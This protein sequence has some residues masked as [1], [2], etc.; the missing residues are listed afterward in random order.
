MWELKTL[1]EISIILNEGTVQLLTDEELEQLDQVTES[2]R[3]TVT[4]EKIA[5]TI[6]FEKE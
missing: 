1:E 6:P 4:L 2:L 3:N 5:R